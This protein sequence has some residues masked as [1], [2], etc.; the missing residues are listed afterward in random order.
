MEDPGQMLVAPH[1]R[2]QQVL[3]CNPERQK[4]GVDHL[5]PVG[6]QI[7]KDVAAL[8]VSTDD[9]VLWFWIGTHKDYDRLLS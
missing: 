3:W 1:R 6:K 5:K 4:T 9:G 2:V 7:Q 8:G